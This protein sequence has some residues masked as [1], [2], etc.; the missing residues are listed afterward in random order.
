MTVAACADLH[1]EV[2]AARDLALL[3]RLASGPRPVLSLAYRAIERGARGGD[4]R[5]ELIAWTAE[6][7]AAYALRRVAPARGDE[8]ARAR[9]A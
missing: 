5:G 4:A 3:A 2:L 7:L 9:R 6:G 1:L 8:R